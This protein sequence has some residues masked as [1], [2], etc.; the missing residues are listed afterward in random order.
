VLQQGTTK[1]MVLSNVLALS[2]TEKSQIVELH[3]KNV[4]EELWEDDANITRKPPPRR[5]RPHSDQE[6]SN[7]FLKQ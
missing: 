1:Y 3:V 4:F 7:H 5:K 2:L 6:V